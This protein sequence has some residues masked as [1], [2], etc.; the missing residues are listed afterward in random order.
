MSGTRID[1]RE[2]MAHQT[3][4]DIL[5][6]ARRLFAERGYAA[7]SIDDIAA[8]AGVAVQTIYARLGS[9]RGMVL[10]LIDLIEEEAD[11]AELRSGVAQASN[12]QEALRAAIRITRT[13]QERCGD[14]IEALFTAAGAEP[15]LADAVAVGHHRH[16]EGARFTIGRIQ[17]LGGLRA[18]VPPKHA[19]ALFSLSTNHEAWRELTEGH[20]LSWDTAE[21]RLTDALTR[22]LLAEPSKH[23]TA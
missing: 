18:D 20:H 9:K 6:A 13:V 3:R 17:E 16:R 2:Q 1:R 11:V 4:R 14:I 21:A 19:Q 23:P 12:P 5:A 22:S 10:A 15:E 7:T 8:E